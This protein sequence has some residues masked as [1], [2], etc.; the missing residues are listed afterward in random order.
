VVEVDQ[1]AAGGD[2]CGEGGG[3]G[4]GLNGGTS[5]RRRDEMA[6]GAHAALTWFETAS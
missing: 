3:T 2:S 4:S 5:N 1:E 6:S